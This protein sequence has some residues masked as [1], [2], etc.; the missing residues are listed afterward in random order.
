MFSVLL[1]LAAA[2]V[3]G[4]LGLASSKKQSKDQ[5]ELNSSL[6]NEQARLNREQYDYE[7]MKESP[8]ARVAQYQQAG[9]NP[10]LMYSNGV[11]GMQGSVS[12]V[13]GSSVGIPNL[14][15][16]FDISE[17]MLNISS[18]REKEGDT[19]PSR[20]DMNLKESRAKLLESLK[21]HEDI[22]AGISKATKDALDNTYSFT[23]TN[24]DGSTTNVQ[25]AGKYM[26]MVKKLESYKSDLVGNS[27]AEY[28]LTKW[29]EYFDSKVA[30][31]NATATKEQANAFVA[32]LDKLVA[33]QLNKEGIYDDAKRAE[34]TKAIEECRRYMA[35]EFD[36]STTEFIYMWTQIATS[37]YDS[38]NPLGLL[39][40]FRKKAKLIDSSTPNIPKK[41]N[42]MDTD[43][44]LSDL[45]AMF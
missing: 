24:A 9:L 8:S 14:S 43:E 23:I 30:I 5:Y 11:A 6:M 36:G 17:N 19:E 29:K 28:E 12:G 31:S 7:Y 41:V 39:K 42:G 16:L 15:N 1:A 27:K 10:A 35:K 22:K 37:I 3:G 33:D 21:G 38:V 2:V 25:V 40:L 44:M 45:E 34:L 18:S 20:V 13:S 26:D 32:E 4:V